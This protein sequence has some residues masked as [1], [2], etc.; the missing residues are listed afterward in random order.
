MIVVTQRP[1]TMAW[2]L[3]E[4]T[5]TG[6]YVRNLLIQYLGHPSL[7]PNSLCCVTTMLKNVNSGVSVSDYGKYAQYRWRWEI[8]FRWKFCPF[9]QYLWI[10]ARLQVKVRDIIWKAGGELVL[11]C[12][13]LHINPIVPVNSN[14]EKKNTFWYKPACPHHGNEEEMTKP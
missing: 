10:F 14:R 2:P 11:L 1:A 8:A 5:T 7:Y 3:D 12:P 6:Q 4:P 9:F 13:S